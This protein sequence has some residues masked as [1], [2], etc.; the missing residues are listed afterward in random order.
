MVI[1][2]RSDNYRQKD[3]MMSQ[4]SIIYEVKETKVQKIRSQRNKCSK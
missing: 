3:Q 2:I 4:V 1:N